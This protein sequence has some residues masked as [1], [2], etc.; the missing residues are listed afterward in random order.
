MVNNTDPSTKLHGRGAADGLESRPQ[1]CRYALAMPA[2]NPARRAVAEAIARVAARFPNLPPSHLDTAALDPADAALATA[3]H[4]TVLQRWLTLEHLLAPLVKPGLARIEPALRAVL[5][6]GGAQLLFMDRLP[7]YAVVNDAAELARAMVR[8]RAAGLANAVLRRVAELPAGRDLDSDWHPAGDVLPLDAGVLRLAR[9]L[10]PDPAER[11]D[12]HLAIATSHPA[13][14]IRRW[15]AHHDADAVSAI[16]RQSIRTPSTFVAVEPGFD[17]ADAAD[18]P[19]IRDQRSEITHLCWQA[20]HASLTRFLA[21]QPLR[22]VQD[23]ASTASVAAARDLPARTILDYCAGRGTKT[24]QLLA[25]HP[26]AAVYAT[27][28]DAARRAELHALARRLPIDVLEPGQRPPAPVDLLLLDVPCSNT[29]VLARRPEA[30]YR[31]NDKSLADVVALQ[32][33][34]IAAALPSLKAGG[35]LLYATCSIEPEENHD[36]ARHVLQHHGGRLIAERQILPGGAGPA[37]HDGSYHAVV[38]W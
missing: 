30:R 34:I 19:A 26:E 31:F 1:R 37:Y 2:V 18:Q 23:P 6:T 32:R 38:Q 4:R 17:P 13:R 3:I 7:A 33:Q 15:L 35:H 8:L 11:L 5:L 22:R 25:E 10:L 14:L 28:P 20:D 12:K 27:D 16:A 21:A 36:Q 24:R 29:G 9:P